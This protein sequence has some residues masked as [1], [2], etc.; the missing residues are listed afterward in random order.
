MKKSYFKWIFTI[1]CLLLVFWLGVIGGSSD[2]KTSEIISVILHK[3]FNLKLPDSISSST[4][5]IVYNVRLPRI[6]L[7]F[8]IGGAIS[9]SGAIMQSILQNP[10][11]SPFTMGVSSGASLGAGIIIITGIKLSFAGTFTLPIVGFLSAFLTV[12]LV[13]SLSQKIDNAMSN[14]TVVLIGMILSLFL[15]SILT[16]LTSLNAGDIKKIIMWQMGTFDNKGWQYVL[17][18][19]PF[20]LFG[21]IIS[22]IYQNKMDIMSFGDMQALTLG[23]NVKKTK[24]ILFITCAVLTGASVS[25]V[26]VIGFV[27]LIVAHII[28]RILGSSHKVVIPMCFLWGGI[29]LILT[30]LISRTII[31]PAIMPIGAITAVLG[32]PFFA[33]IFFSKKK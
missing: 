8:F 22:A 11:A 13:I 12:F 17:A 31:S 32:A 10:L 7:A 27:D 16:V 20:Y 2:I 25:L 14:Q 4:V 6:F 26:G 29:F 21:V 5:A 15:N 1:F 24:S 30:D 19:I 28:R 3:F 18:I 33:I 23:V 9:V